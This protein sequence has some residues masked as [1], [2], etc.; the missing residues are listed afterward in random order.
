MTC[1]KRCRNGYTGIA[2]F[3]FQIPNTGP[4][5]TLA[6]DILAKQTLVVRRL[7]SVI[8]HWMNE[9]MDGNLTHTR[10]IIPGFNLA[11]PA[12]LNPDFQR[13]LQ[14]RQA[15]LLAALVNHIGTTDDQ[16]VKIADPPRILVVIGQLVQDIAHRI[17]PCALLAI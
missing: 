8:C 11:D 15:L 4:L 16:R 1:T 5:S 6:S 17:K 9:P 10:A 13:Q 3:Q 12:W 7:K 14:N 2:D